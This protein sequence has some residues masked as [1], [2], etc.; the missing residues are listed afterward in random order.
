MVAPFEPAKAE[1]ISHQPNW[2][3][4]QDVDYGA[5]RLQHVFVLLFSGQSRAISLRQSM[6]FSSVSCSSL[7]NTHVPKTSTSMF[8][9]MKQR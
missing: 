5:Q 3:K 1:Q 7:R 4:Y 2:K 9:R 6:S 8:V